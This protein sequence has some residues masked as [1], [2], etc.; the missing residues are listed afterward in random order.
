MDDQDE[1]WQGE[2]V[3]TEDS[4]TIVQSN[5]NLQ[6]KC[7]GRPANLD[8]KGLILSMHRNV[9]SKKIFIFITLDIDSSLPSKIEP[10]YKY[11]ARKMD[12]RRAY[13]LFSGS[14]KLI[15]FFDKYKDRPEIRDLNLNFGLENWL[16]KNFE[17]HNL[18][19]FLEKNPNMNI[20]QKYDK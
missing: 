13:S 5:E 1:P 8:V 12:H 20:Q 6:V 2:W 11:M 16:V 15:N 14:V 18:K 3:D 9:N 7:V 4:I 10:F 17:S 19:M